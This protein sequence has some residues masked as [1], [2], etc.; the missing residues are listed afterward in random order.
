MAIEKLNSIGVVVVSVTSDN[1]SSN[2]SMFNQLGAR[3]H[4]KTPKV[5]L[6]VKNI[7]DIPVFVTL[8]ACHL[9][10]LVRNS[11]GD[12]ISFVNAD[13]EE[14]NWTYIVKLCELQNENGLHLASKLRNQHI[15][16][17]SDKMKTKLAVQTLSKSTANA[18]SLCEN[19]LKKP[20]FKGAKATSEFCQIFNDVFD[21]LN[22]KSKFGKGYSAPIDSESYE[23]L[24]EKFEYIEKYIHGLKMK[25]GHL[26]IE[27]PRKSA[28]LGILITLKSFL[29]IYQCY[30]QTRNIQYLLTYKFSQD[31][32]GVIE[33]SII[34]LLILVKILVLF[35]NY[36]E[37]VELRLLR[38]L[39][40]Y[41]F[42]PFY[43]ANF[44]LTLS[45]H[46][47]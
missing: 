34:F 14:I 42:L 12:Y 32:L 8:D 43:S 44:I 2:W 23:H 24:K 4:D 40:N 31:H 20:E 13:E 9:I 19:V 1:P 37:L 45:L 16:F 47:S 3:L 11:I 15:D 39:N 41:Q 22:S 35:T 30:V 7:M 28:F 27:G 38:S 6:N 21:I 18:L 25:N 36:V 5:S 46:S 17:S 10:K 29:Y 33:D 26:V